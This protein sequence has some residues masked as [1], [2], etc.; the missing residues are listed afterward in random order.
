MAERNL[1]LGERVLERIALVV[2]KIDLESPRSPG[3]IIK[4]F[5]EGFAYRYF[6]GDTIIVFF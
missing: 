3:K 6:N 1:C 4:A 5:E 2:G